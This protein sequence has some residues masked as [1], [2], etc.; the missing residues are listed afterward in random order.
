MKLEQAASQPD[1]YFQRLVSSDEHKLR[2][3]DYRLLAALD[4]QNRTILVEAVDHRSRIY[5]RAG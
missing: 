4:P 5:Q 3:G 2:V 1:R